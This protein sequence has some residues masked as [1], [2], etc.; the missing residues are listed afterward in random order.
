MPTTLKSLAYELV[1]STERTPWLEESWID[2]ERAYA[3]PLPEGFIPPE[4]WPAWEPRL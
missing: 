2:K 1:R 4:L 3:K